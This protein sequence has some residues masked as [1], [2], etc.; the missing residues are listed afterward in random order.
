MEVLPSMVWV[1]SQGS[2]RQISLFPN[3]LAQIHLN[4]LQLLPTKGDNSPG[5]DFS[6]EPG[7]K[8]T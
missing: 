7:I 4:C 5:V 8:R 3:F 6:Q 1:E 2:G